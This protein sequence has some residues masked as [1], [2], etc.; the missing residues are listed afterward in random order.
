MKVLL[1]GSG[2]REHAMARALERSGHTIVWAPGNGAVGSWRRRPV[3]LKNLELVVRLALEE[4][5]DLTLIGPEDPLAA[6]L[7]DCLQQVGLKAWGPNA[8]QAQLE[9]S[10]AW[11]K[12]FMARHGL[13]TAPFRVTTNLDQARQAIEELQPVVVKADGLAAGKGVVV[14]DTPQEALH[15]AGRLGPKLVIEKR[16]QGPE[17][18]LILLLRPDGYQA[19]PLVRDH[20]RLLNGDQGPNT[21]GMGAYYPIAEAPPLQDLLD[22]LWHGLVQENLNYFGALFLG[23]I[24]TAEGPQLLEF[25]CRLGDPETEVLLESLQGDFVQALF[26]EPLQLAPGCHIDVVLASA[27]YPA[28][29]SSGQIITG[30]ENLTEATLLHAGSERLPDGTLVTAGGRVLHLVASASNLQQARQR[31]EQAARQIR[32]DGQA[33][34][35]RSDIGAS[36]S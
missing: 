9:S 7:V 2:G 22:K 10:K 19:F 36:R 27:G 28:S 20:K 26:G 29:S 6:G 8:H 16:L 1:L 24:L 21:G 14:A 33:P 4:Q 23:L 25:N 32:F 5:P 34:Q 3:D 18:S 31:V 15:A 30:H 11:A 13:P 12:E 17:A 35:W